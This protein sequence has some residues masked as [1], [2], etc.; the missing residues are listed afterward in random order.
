MEESEPE[1]MN[2]GTEK[3][4]QLKTGWNACRKAYKDKLLKAINKELL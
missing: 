2:D 3:Y 1:E 4:H